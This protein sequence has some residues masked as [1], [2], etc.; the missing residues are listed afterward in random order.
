MI[1]EN[2]FVIHFLR[3]TEH[4]NLFGAIRVIRLLLHLCSKM[5]GWLPES[6]YNTET[7]EMLYDY[8]PKAPQWCSTEE[9]SI[10]LVNIDICKCYPSILLSNTRPI[11]ICTIHDTI[12]KVTHRSELDKCG[13]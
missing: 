1:R 6:K 11:P 13:E 2:Q 9:R 3:D 4:M 12:E 8:Y 10:D 7:R 5:C